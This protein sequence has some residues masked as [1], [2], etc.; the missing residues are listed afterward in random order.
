MLKTNINTIILCSLLFT[1]Q[2]TSQKNSEQGIA[3]KGFDFT[4]LIGDLRSSGDKDTTS[5]FIFYLYYQPI[6]SN[7]FGEGKGFM[8]HKKELNTGLI[9]HKKNIR[10]LFLE[11]ITDTKMQKIICKRKIAHI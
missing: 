8:I 10:N 3:Y 9:L 7:Q 5:I 6:L 1:N 11:K 4:S 2:C